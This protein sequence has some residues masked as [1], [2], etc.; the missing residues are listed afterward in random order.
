MKPDYRTLVRYLVEPLIEDQQSL[1]VDIESTGGGK[2]VWVRLSFDA[3]DRGRV[4]GRGGRTLQAIRQV[5]TTAARLAEQTLRL[6]I[7]DPQRPSSP[8]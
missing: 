6:E 5:M 8:H 3:Q 2:R 7:Y 4:F 1:R